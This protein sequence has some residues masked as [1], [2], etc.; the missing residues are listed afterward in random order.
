MDKLRALLASDIPFARDDAHRLLPAMIACLCGFTALLLALAVSLSDNVE[1]QA[2]QV[3]GVVQVE[4]PPAVVKN[5]DKFSTII[6][7]VRRTPGV[8]HVNVLREDDMEKLLKPWLGSDFTLDDLPVPSMLDVSTEVKDGKP[9]ID[10]PKLKS[11]LSGIDKNIVVADR[12]PW[13]GNVERAAMLL[14]WLVLLIA[15]LLMACV[16]GMIVLVARTNLKLH[17]KA[18]SLLHMF[19]ATDDYILQQFQWNNAFL[20]I[21]GAAVGTLFAALVFTAWVVLSNRW[22]NPVLPPVGFTLSHG[23]AFALLPVMT[24]VIAFA[25]TR[26]TVHNMLRHMH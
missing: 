20:A 14:Q 23:L 25:A 22:D 11:T 7:V 26:V 8:T 10:L 6:D 2:R 4:I 15:A 16:I 1:H 21:R 17:F 5:G 19:G 12:G 18:V 9:A 3:T 13:V 24:A